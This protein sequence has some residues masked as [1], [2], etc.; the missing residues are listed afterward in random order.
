MLVCVF[1]VCSF[2]AT[3]TCYRNASTCAGCARSSGVNLQYVE[4]SVPTPEPGLCYHP[5][6]QS[7]AVCE[8]ACE[9][10]W[11]LEKNGNTTAEFCH[12]GGGY[13][14][15]NQAACEGVCNPGKSDEIV[16][17]SGRTVKTMS[18][19]TCPKATTSAA[20]A[21]GSFLKASS[22]CHLGSSGG[23][24]C[25]TDPDFA[26][27]TPALFNRVSI[28]L[29]SY[30][31]MGKFEFHISTLLLL[32]L[33]VSFYG[34]FLVPWCFL[35]YT[36]ATF[37]TEFNSDFFFSV[38]VQSDGLVQNLGTVGSRPQGCGCM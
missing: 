27:C 8:S 20:I 2:V 21:G 22:C 11:A 14:D 35:P 18:Y 9:G 4:C 36:N 19:G 24:L 6:C 15:T 16:Y 17:L 12:L 34:E 5:Q 1:F 31:F 7:Q 28:C 23:G 10:T 29:P 25:P 30:S 13:C 32:L 38:R 26:H 37:Q 33:L 3:G